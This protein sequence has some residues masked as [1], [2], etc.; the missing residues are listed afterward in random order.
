MHPERNCPCRGLGP[1]RAGLAISQVVTYSFIS[2][3]NNKSSRT[4]WALDSKT[5]ESNGHI[6]VVLCHITNAWHVEG[7][8]DNMSSGQ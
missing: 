7:V 5:H 2:K 1:R 4:S 3:G 8:Q 6:C